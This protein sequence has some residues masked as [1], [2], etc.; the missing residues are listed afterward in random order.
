MKRT[1]ISKKEVGYIKIVFYDD[2]SVSNDVVLPKG[3]NFLVDRGVSALESLKL[4]IIRRAEKL[5]KYETN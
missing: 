4:E 1:N 5:E 3:V 2:G